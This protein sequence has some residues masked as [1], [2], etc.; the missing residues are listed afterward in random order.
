MIENQVA[1]IS[2]GEGIG[3]GGPELDLKQ[4]FDRENTKCG[5][6]VGLLGHL[7]DN[8]V[9]FSQPTW[10]SD[11]C[12]GILQEVECR[13]VIGYGT[14]MGSPVHFVFWEL[15]SRFLKYMKK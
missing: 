8:L 14:C 6:V 1:I 5:S 2:G 9:G 11:I 12:H 15:G 4:G 10:N 7:L 3:G 13:N